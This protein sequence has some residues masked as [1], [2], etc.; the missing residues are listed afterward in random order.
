M[1]EHVVSDGFR[2]RTADR[3]KTCPAYVLQAP[4]VNLSTYTEWAAQS[5]DA[6]L[7]DAAMYADLM[8]SNIPVNPTVV[9]LPTA[10]P[11]PDAELEPTPIPVIIEISDQEISWPM[12][13][14]TPVPAEFV[15][16]S[17]FVLEDDTLFTAGEQNRIQHIQAE[18]AAGYVRHAD[19]SDMVVLVSCSELHTAV[20]AS[21]QYEASRADDGSWLISKA[22]S[23]GDPIRIQ[24]R[25]NGYAIT[26]LGKTSMF[27]ASVDDNHKGYVMLSACEMDVIHTDDGTLLLQNSDGSDMQILTMDN[28]P[29][30]LPS[31]MALCQVNPADYDGE[32]WYLMLPARELTENDLLAVFD[33]FDL[34]GLTFDPSQISIRNCCRGLGYNRALQ[35]DETMRAETLS[36]LVYNDLIPSE[37]DMGGNRNLVLCCKNGS[38][39]FLRPYSSMR[40]EELVQEVNINSRPVIEKIIEREARELLNK[41]F[42][43]PLSL[44]CNG[45]TFGN[46]SLP[47]QGITTDEHRLVLKQSDSFAGVS[48]DLS[49]DSDSYSYV[50]VTFDDVLEGRVL[51]VV[52][53]NVPMYKGEIDD[54]SIYRLK[55]DEKYPELLTVAEQFA[56]RYFSKFALDRWYQATG[57][58]LIH[59]F[60]AVP[61]KP[62]MILYTYTDDALYMLTIEEDGIVREAAVYFFDRSVDLAKEMAEH[63][64]DYGFGDVL[65]EMSKE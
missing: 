28:D 32:T 51:S 37:I 34:I 63:P 19:G 45:Y 38:V 7:P 12:V 58:Q 40:D 48:F 3:R 18:R 25:E 5:A 65:A 29:I 22:D 46:G 54:S 1:T 33:A 36:Q 62:Y 53:T 21:D 55:T 26:G 57:D 23:S 61:V 17:G 50:D 64:D 27:W 41:Y 2:Y 31:D 44:A 47:V 52:Y 42:D 56:G 8:M 13:Q 6:Y 39:F 43:F 35:A 59:I 10:T 20:A 60:S 14:S 30:T 49:Q 24:V 9:P 4:D 11:M 16:G 15:T